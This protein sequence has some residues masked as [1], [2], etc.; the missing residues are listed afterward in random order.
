MNRFDSLLDRGTVLFD[1][2]MGTELM[3]RGVDGDRCLEELN[4]SQPALVRAIHH[5]YIAAGADVIETNTFGANWFRLGEHYLEAQVKEINQAGARLALEA[6]NASGRQVLVAASVGP[7]GRPIEPIGSIKL[8]SAERIY[9][10]QLDALL[11]AGVDV[12]VFETFTALAEL[13]IAVRIARELSPQTPVLAQMS[14][15]Q[16]G[17]GGAEG[18]AETVVRALQPLGV[19]AVGVNCGSGPQDALEAA[20]ALISAGAEN[21]SVM[22]NAGLPERVGGRLLYASGPDYFADY[23]RRFKAA[24][25][26]IVGGCCG[27]N[28]QHVAAMRAALDEEIGSA[29]QAQ[30]PAGR[31][32]GA[33]AASPAPPSRLAAQLAE[34]RFAISVELTPPR[35]VDPRRMLEG[36]RLLKEAGVDFANVTDSAMARL[37]MGAV[38]CAALVQQQV[39]LEAIAHFTTRDRNVMAIQSELIGAHALGLRNLLCMRGD[40]LGI[41]DHPQAAT[42]WEVNSVGL[43]T[44]VAN[45]NRGLDAN[46]S[47]IG[48][49]ASFFIG[50]AVNPNAADQ[51]REIRLLRRKLDAGAHFV[52]AQPMYDLR[53]LEAFLE[54]SGPLAVPILVGVMPLVSL[55]HAEYIHNEVPGIEVPAAAL[56]RI[57][58]AGEEASRVGL[59]MAVELLEGARGWVQGAYV[60]PFRG[61][62]ELA[63]QVVARAREMV[64]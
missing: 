52:V 10:E 48:G 13:E 49:A 53:T 47:P 32:Q 31:G 39:G 3:A 21:V 9:R 35:G 37:R 58:A 46:G 57:A 22:P 34:G 11:G 24:G 30:A 29:A 26:R 43:I 28:P 38:S 64:G 44:I 2:A 42:V 23:A 51:A 41:G 55:R 16:D 1:G 33:A 62:Y 20:Q 40:P 59:E 17:L 61:R 25:I 36:A 56:D 12:I 15:D 14:F 63:A 54:R 27:T 5:D 60:I 19:K 18:I 7:L 45:L 4:L 50:A 6:R 8:S